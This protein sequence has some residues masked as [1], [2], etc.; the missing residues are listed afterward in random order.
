MPLI[1]GLKVSRVRIN[2]LPIFENNV[3]NSHGDGNGIH[4]NQ[5]LLIRLDRLL[6]VWVQERSSKVFVL[7][8]P[9]IAYAVVCKW[10]SS[11]SIENL[12]P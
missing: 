11:G 1:F 12:L 8:H 3:L 2:N 10:Y 9:E 5:I 6:I 4:I 7:P